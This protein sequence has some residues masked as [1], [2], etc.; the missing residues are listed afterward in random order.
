MDAVL[1]TIV[2][3]IVLIILSSLCFLTIV[4]IFEKWVDSHEDTIEKIE[5]IFKRISKIF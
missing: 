1:Y 3:S 5:L 2:S 4:Y